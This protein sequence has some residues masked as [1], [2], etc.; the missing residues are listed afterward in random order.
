MKGQIM[1]KVAV[2]GKQR[3]WLIQQKQQLKTVEATVKNCKVFYTFP[4]G[5]EILEILLH[6]TNNMFA[7]H[8]MQKHQRISKMYSLNSSYYT[9]LL[10]ARQL[11]SLEF[12]HVSNAVDTINHKHV[13]MG[14]SK[15]QLQKHH[16]QKLFPCNK[17]NFSF[18]LRIHMLTTIKYYV[19][20]TFHFKDLHKFNVITVF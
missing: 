6:A 15:L 18:H 10:Y 2:D 3:L 13:M 14:H 8:K 11:T 12:P 4:K 5:P 16:S 7:Y 19:V 17:G 20:L 9:I 1:E